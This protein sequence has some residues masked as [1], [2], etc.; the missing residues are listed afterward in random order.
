MGTELHEWFFVLYFARRPSTQ[1]Q[2]QKKKNEKKKTTY[3]SMTI[4]STF[5][6]SNNS[7]NLTMFGW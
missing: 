7:T 4:Y 6:L 2:N 5:L 3:K 1:N